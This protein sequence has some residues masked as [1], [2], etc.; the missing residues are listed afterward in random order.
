MAI[1]FCLLQK[2][3]CAGKLGGLAGNVQCSDH[4]VESWSDTQLVRN[5]RC[6]YF[7]AMLTTNGG[8]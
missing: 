8:G 7:A 6:V 3:T 5:K 2:R 4:A 1:V